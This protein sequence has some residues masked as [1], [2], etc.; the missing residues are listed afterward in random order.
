MR[1][2]F[3]LGSG[4]SSDT[5]RSP[6]FIEVKVPFLQ[7]ALGP[8]FVHENR[9]VERLTS[10]SRMGMNPRYEGPSSNRRK[11]SS[12]AKIEST[13]SFGHIRFLRGAR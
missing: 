5:P 11:R 4:K 8:G 1:I 10:K 6:V 12:H 2:A 7:T 9:D 13:Q 3:S